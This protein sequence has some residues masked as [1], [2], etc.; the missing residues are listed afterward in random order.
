VSAGRVVAE[1]QTRGRRETESSVATILQSVQRFAAA[2]DAEDYEVVRGCLAP[3]CVYAA[4][5]GSLVGPDAIVASY[6]G[7]GSAARGR[8]EKI[9]YRSEVETIGPSDAIITFI[10]RV[11]LASKWHEFRCRQR[12]RLGAGGLIEEIT[13]EEIPGERERLHEFEAGASGR[14]PV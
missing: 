11:M 2:L 10:D 5:E 9:E 1:W 6:D 8:F 13:Q 14:N 4:L 12:L 3:A 7:N